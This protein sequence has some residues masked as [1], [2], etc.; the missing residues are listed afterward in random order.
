MSTAT[1]TT[2]LCVFAFVKARPGKEEEVRSILSAAV[3]LTHQDPDCLQYDL[4][5]G[6][7]DPGS[8]AFY[9]RWRDQ[10]ALDAHLKMPYI[11]SFFARIPELLSEPPTMKSYKLHG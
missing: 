8:F 10:A 1:P 11:Q 4:H 5:V 6:L 3:A 2:M 7:G 9:E